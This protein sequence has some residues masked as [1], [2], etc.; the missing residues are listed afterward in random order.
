[1]NRSIL[2]VDDEP[3][4]CWVI[5]HILQSQG[6]NVVTVYSGEEACHKLTYGE[7]SF[8][9]LDAKLPDMDGLEVARRAST[10]ENR[11]RIVMVSGYHYY[12]DPVI[13]HAI[14]EGIICGFLA[15]PF[16]NKDLLA[17]LQTLAQFSL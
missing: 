15:K 16:G 3:D 14:S 8:V 10:L 12:D 7:F 9:F 2:I 4:M 1:M 6:L 11:P 13:R 17:T 5:A